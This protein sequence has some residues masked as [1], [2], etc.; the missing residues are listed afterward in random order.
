MR[1]RAT[2]TIVSSVSAVCAPREP[3]PGSCLWPPSGRTRAASSVREIHMS[4]AGPHPSKWSSA[5]GPR[6]SSRKSATTRATAHSP[7]VSIT[8]T[9]SP[10]MLR[11]APTGAPATTAAAAAAAADA[12]NAVTG[13]PPPLLR[14]PP[15]LKGGAWRGSRLSCA[16]AR[17][18]SEWPPP[19]P[20]SNERSSTPPPGAPS[21]HSP[22]KGSVASVHS[23]GAVD[24]ERRAQG[25]GGAPP[26]CAG[27]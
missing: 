24:E 22:G 11:S 8:S 13:A 5:S 16:P 4:H 27:P 15:L 21:N 18:C 23:C 10:T 7:C 2:P 14:A 1:C 20:T 25:R 12:T 26:P 9:Q 17:T 19:P 6:L 3:M